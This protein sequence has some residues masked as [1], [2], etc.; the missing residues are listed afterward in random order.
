MKLLMSLGIFYPSQIGGPANTLYWIGKSLTKKGI[1]VTAIVSDIGVSKNFVIS[2]Q[3]N[4]L[5]GIKIKYCHVNKFNG[6]LKLTIEALK[7]VPKNDV[8]MLS[9][10]FYKPNFFVGIAALIFN[11]KIIWSPRGELLVV[12]GAIK[13]NYLRI[14]ND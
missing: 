10:I 3:W 7:E 2:D 4:N 9:S 14:I 13:K 1:D 12:M 6:F 5:D 8:V 11:K